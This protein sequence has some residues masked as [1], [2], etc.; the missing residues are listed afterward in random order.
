MTNKEVFDKIF[1]KPI[2]EDW[3]CKDCVRRGRLTPCG[4]CD[5]W[6][7]EY[8]G[9]VFEEKKPPFKIFITP[10]M[11]VTRAVVDLNMK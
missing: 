6:D 4:A 10:P 5:W 1:N 11:G 8:T 2:F 9:S 7:K 3:R